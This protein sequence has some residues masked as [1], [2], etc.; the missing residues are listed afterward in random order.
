MRED[1]WGGGLITRPKP[2]F[3]N[4][5]VITIDLGTILVCHPRKKKKKE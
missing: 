4:A 3:S 1:R 5:P 2:S